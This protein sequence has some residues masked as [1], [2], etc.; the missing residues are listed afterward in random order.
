MKKNKRSSENGTEALSSVDIAP[1]ALANLADKLK[2][3]LANPNRPQKQ[4]S[5][6]HSKEKNAVEKRQTDAGQNKKQ[7]KKGS[8]EKVTAKGNKA[9]TESTR[10]TKDSSMGTNGVSKSLAK[11]TEN[12]DGRD[13]KQIRKPGA[14]QSKASSKPVV[15]VKGAP[16]KKGKNPKGGASAEESMASSL[17]EEILALGGTKED[18]ELVEDIDSEDEIVG[19]L[20]PLKGQKSRQKNDNQTVCT[21]AYSSNN[22][23]CNESYESNL[24]H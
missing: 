17:L 2:S 24:S 3:D 12:K 14:V 20:Q 18:L 10:A 15:S 7:A 4:S 5:R 6:K 11:S 1:E 16:L 22:I 9:V 13:A 19:E 21:I 23:S 8:N